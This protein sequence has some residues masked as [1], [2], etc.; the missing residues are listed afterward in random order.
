[1]NARA[2]ALGALALAAALG[3]ALAAA[4]GARAPR[5][6]PAPSFAAAIGVLYRQCARWAVA[7][8]Q[9][10]SPMIAVLHANY[11]AG[12]L[13]AIKDIATP[14][15]FARATGGAD[16]LALERRVVAVQDAA[17]RALLAACDRAAP[18]ADATLRAAMYYSPPEQAP[19]Q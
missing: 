9:D 16:F 11:A 5:A 15:Q 3:A 6:A 10:A 1:M 4:L 2:R 12:Y 7:S 18:V 19:A 17:A 14:E 8:L 13:W